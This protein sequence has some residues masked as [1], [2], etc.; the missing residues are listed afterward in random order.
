M[1]LNEAS[2]E[3]VTRNETDNFENLIYLPFVDIGLC[4]RAYLFNA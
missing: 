3:E 1:T 4:V 2:W